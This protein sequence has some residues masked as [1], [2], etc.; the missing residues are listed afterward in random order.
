MISLWSSRP[1]LIQLGLFFVAYFLG[2]ALADVLGIVPGTNISIWPPGG[3]FMATLISTPKRTWPWW[4]FAG[5]LAEMLGQ[6]CFFQ[7]PPLPSFIM[8]LGNALEAAVGACLVNRASGR[9]LRLD[10]P[11]DVLAFLVFG[12][13]VAPALSATVGAATLAAFHIRN[14]SFGAAWLLWWIGDA[15][16]ILIVTPL[17]IGVLRTWRDNS[18]LSKARWVE[19]SALGLVFLAV[20]IIS[21]SGRLPFAYLILPPLLWAAV[22]FELRGAVVAL[23]TL[24]L[25]TTAFTISGTGQFA[26]DAA[27]QREKLIELQLF[28]AISALS[29]LMVAA[30]SRQHHLATTT[31]RQSMEAL[32]AR[33]RELSHLV[34]MTPSH[35]WRLT[36]EGEPTF[37]NQRMID[38][39]GPDVMNAKHSGPR[40][41]GKL[42]QA[43]VHPDDLAS[44]NEALARSLETGEAFAARYR[45]RRADGVYSW[46]SSSAEPSRDQCGRILQWH[47]LCHDIDDQMRLYRDVEER[48]AKIRRLVDS[49]IIGIVIWDLS[50]TLIDANDAF[51]RMVQYDR[52]DLKAGLDWLAMT[53][54]EWQ[55]IHAREEAAEL[56]RTGK[57]QAR[58]KEYFR[59]DGSRV[60]I[61][62]GGACFEGIS[63]QGVA[64]ILDLTER[65]R[66]EQALRESERKLW[67]L[68]E[69]LPVMIDCAAPDGEPMYR[70][71]QL[72]E[73]LGFEP[74]KLDGAEKARLNGPLNDSV[75]PDDEAAV[76]KLYAHSLATGETYARRHRLRRFDGEYLWVDTRAAPMRD[77]QGAIVQ[78][79]VTCLDID[80]EVRAQEE[81]RLAH[82]RLARASEAASL[83]ELAASIA[84]EVNQPLAAVVAHSHACQ[85]WLRAAPPNLERAQTTVERIIRDANGAADVVS[86]I[87]AL[88][89]Q[90]VRV[91]GGSSL[92]SIISDA[93]RSILDLALRHRVLLDVQVEQDVPPLAIDRVQIQQVLINLMRNAVEA[94]AADSRERLL[95]VR[96]SRDGDAVRIEVRD[97]GP[98]F[99]DADKIFDPFFTTKENGMGMGLAISRSI[100]ESHRG[101]LWVESNDAHG[102]SFIFVL[103]IEGPVAV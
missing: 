12:A 70:S 59:K 26:G 103:P 83:A 44:F 54:P 43:V 48:E 11:R 87:R 13:G 55:E 72:R 65:K 22:R 63:T 18:R 101:R 96:A 39:L 66:T 14:Q 71:R 9:S 47:G 67:Q 56:A 95:A 91:R 97:T 90:K 17:V 40:G 57:M 60:P 102:A 1:K 3:M 37:F 68:V 35:V 41:F 75:H 77:A 78:W 49:D 29:A 6:L 93:E 10:T 19:A 88:F 2:C 99:E 100:V 24:V 15:T 23:I 82:E 20:A 80:A 34:N 52:E 25:V 58:E 32:Q 50:G 69:T 42:M 30:I 86:R 76:K 92:T 31:L 62:I 7:S 27:S 64:F 36:P 38:Y 21:Q 94:M 8:Y 85:R 84:H 46:M 61:L 98:G 51:L 28:L 53:P 89:R 79:N 73:F 45:L 33:E 81:L 74:D 4:A 16:G 5:C